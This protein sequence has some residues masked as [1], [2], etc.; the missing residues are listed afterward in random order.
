MQSTP[1]DIGQLLK[2]RREELGCSLEHAEESTRI[3]KSFLVCLEENRFADLP[4]QAYVTGF[5]RL[6]AR[7]LGLDSA[8]L[9]SK[10]HDQHSFEDGE[11]STVKLAH[12]QTKVLNRPTASTGRSRSL[13][14]LAVIFAIAVACYILSSLLL[15]EDRHELA[16]DPPAMEQPA[17]TPPVP[18]EPQPR[19]ESTNLSPLPSA[20]EQTL[21]PQTVIPEPDKEARRPFPAIPSN[22]ASLRMLAVADGALVITVDTR[23]PHQYTLHDG[24]DLTWNVK[25]KVEV[26]FA[27]RDVA[28]FWLNGE[29][30]DMTG[31][32]S[33]QLQPAE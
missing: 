5:I 33:F 11:Q 26:K 27:A 13:L 29:E 6:Y 10:L 16:P 30:L 28:R 2:E 12:P 32:D 17:G 31:L 4:G 15:G 20:P 18:P 19:A 22:G 24:L 7:Y 8:P 25:E 9:L 23:E 3:R 21:A 14:S 1:D